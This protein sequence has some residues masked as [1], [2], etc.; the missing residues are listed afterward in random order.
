MSVNNAHTYITQ[1]FP[2]SYNT[3]TYGAYNPLE[4]SGSNFPCQLGVPGM[5]ASGPTEATVSIPFDI[6][7]AGLATHGGG[8]C[9]VSI[10]PGFNPSRNNANFRVIK[11][12]YGCLTTNGGNIDSNTSPNTMTA[13]IPAGVEPGEYTQSWTWF[14]K[15]T[16]ELCMMCAPIK[17]IASKAKRR[18]E[19]QKLAIDKRT[20]D[21]LPPIWLANL[22]EVTGSCGV[23]PQQLVVQVPEP[24]R[25]V[26]SS[27]PE[28]T[29]MFK[30]ECNGNPASGFAE[31][32][33]GTESVA[34]SSLVARPT[35]ATANTISVV[36]S[37]PSTSAT[38]LTSF[39]PV[40][41]PTPSSLRP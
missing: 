16:N 36:L 5:P 17:I 13:T 34:P 15:T 12:H 30:A 2:F 11:I 37:K 18:I 41:T 33:P 22:G 3:G 20:L 39:S 19:R 1:E 27:L 9:Q 4:P 38:A 28:G 23:Q 31:T 26:E 25:D 32:L 7:F 8:M 14:S 10:L 29:K 21:D 40:T 35:S 6:T 24:G